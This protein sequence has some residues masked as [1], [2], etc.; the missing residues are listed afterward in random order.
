MKEAAISVNHFKLFD[1]K[2]GKVVLFVLVLTKKTVEIFKVNKVTLWNFDLVIIAQM[3]VS[4]FFVQ[5]KQDKLELSVNQQLLNEYRDIKVFD[6]NGAVYCTL[7]KKTDDNQI[8]L[9]VF[10]LAITGSS[11]TFELVNYNI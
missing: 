11:V 7:I 10:Q 2:S 8:K 5:F 1:P 6:V 4:I 3:F 9:G